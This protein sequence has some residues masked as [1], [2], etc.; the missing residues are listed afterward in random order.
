[1]TLALKEW[2]A[3][4]EALGKG[5]SILLFRKGGIRENGGFQ[6][7]SHRAFLLPSFEHQRENLLKCSDLKAS[8][9]PY[10]VNEPISIQY[11]VKIFQLLELKTADCI[12]KLRTFHIWTDEFLQQR[13]AWKPERPLYALL[14]QTYKLPEPVIVPYQQEYG[15]CRSWIHIKDAIAFDPNYPVM[16][17]ER[18]Q[19]EAAHINTLLEHLESPKQ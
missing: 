8:P 14:C 17:V 3:A 1:M 18:F 9:K 11:W 5:E 16:P 10:Q 7:P 2:P 15:G 12:S 6:L 19:T 4:I 13:L